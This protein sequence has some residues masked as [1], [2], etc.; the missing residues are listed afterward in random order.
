MVARDCS[1]VQQK[2]GFLFTFTSSDICWRAIDTNSSKDSSISACK[3]S[4]QFCSKIFLGCS[5]KPLSPWI[6]WFL[7]FTGIVSIVSLIEKRAW[8]KGYNVSVFTMRPRVRI[9]RYLSRKWIIDN[10]DLVRRSQHASHLGCDW[11]AYHIDPR[12]LSEIRLMKL[13]GICR[14]PTCKTIDGFDTVLSAEFHL[15]CLG[16]CGML[17][18]HK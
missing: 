18:S 4:L 11:K 15:K 13:Y 16:Q 6:C 10:I 1:F 12:I 9:S 8:R 17:F 3:P 2:R 14:W 5:V 7:E